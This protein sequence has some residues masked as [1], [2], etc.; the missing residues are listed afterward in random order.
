MS[1]D[2]GKT[3]PSLPLPL[4]T[5]VHR[6]AMNLIQNQYG[7]L[8]NYLDGYYTMDEN[9]YPLHDRLSYSKKPSDLI[10]QYHDQI[11]RCQSGSGNNLYY[12]VCIY[13]LDRYFDALMRD[14]VSLK[15]FNEITKQSFIGGKCPSF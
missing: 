4:P 10:R 14:E 3:T 1:T 2:N 11:R 13:H 9:H 7:F 15:A 8:K 6:E 12:R 5:S